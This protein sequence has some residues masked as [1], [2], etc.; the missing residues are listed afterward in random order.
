[1][2]YFKILLIFFLVG[3]SFS[4]A[5]HAEWFDGEVKKVD[6]KTGMITISEIDPITETEESEEFVV[7]SETVFSGVKSLEEIHVDDD[8]SIEAKY[9]EPSDS[10]KAVSV[11]V[12]EAGD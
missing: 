5:A 9:D 2:K 6:I 7:G 3:M 8:V 12:P 1:M 10:W 4:A 11:E